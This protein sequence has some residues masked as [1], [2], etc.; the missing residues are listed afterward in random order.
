MRAGGLKSM[1]AL[2]IS[3]TAKWL[4]LKMAEELMTVSVYGDR[5]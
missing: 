5:R 4:T 3:S 1:S 2:S